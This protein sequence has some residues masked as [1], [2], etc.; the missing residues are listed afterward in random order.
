MTVA[1]MGYLKSHPETKQDAQLQKLSSP[2]ACEVQFHFVYLL[3]LFSH[4]K[5]RAPKIQVARYIRFPKV[6]PKNTYNP[7]SHGE[8]SFYASSIHI[9]SDGKYATLCYT[10]KDV[11]YFYN[12]TLTSL[13]SIVPLYH[14]TSGKYLFLKADI[15]YGLS[16]MSIPKSWYSVK[17][18]NGDIYLVY[19]IF[20]SK[21]DNSL[22]VYNITKDKIIH[23][24]RYFNTSINE[25]R[26]EDCSRILGNSFVII[27]TYRDLNLRIDLV[28]LVSETVDTFNYTIH[29]YLNNLL[30][31]VDDEIEKKSI[32][33]I[34]S[35]LNNAYIA[36]YRG[37]DWSFLGIM[38]TINN[39]EDLVPFIN[40][41][42]LYL[43][44]KSDIENI[45]LNQGTAV[46]LLK[47][48]IENNELS[49]EFTTWAGDG[50]RKLNDPTFKV[51][52][53]ANAVLFRKRY[54]LDDRYDI[55]KSYPYY[56]HEVAPNY[57]FTTDGVLEQ[58]PYHKNDYIM[59]PGFSYAYVHGMIRQ[60]G[61]HR[62]NGIN[63]LKSNVQTIVQ[64]KRS[65][66]K[67]GRKLGAII[68][69]AD[70]GEK[71][72]HPETI[73]FFNL[74]KAHKFLQKNIYTQNE[75]S[76]PFIDA[77]PFIFKVNV[78][79]KIPRILK[80]SKREL[81]S[82]S[83]RLT[84]FVY[85][86]EIGGLLYI[87]IVLFPKK[88]KNDDNDEGDTV[89]WL[90]KCNILVPTVPCEVITKL[91]LGKSGMVKDFIDAVRHNVHLIEKLGNL[92]YENM[93]V[94]NSYTL[95]Y[96]YDNILIT[97]SD[98]L[99]MKIKDIKQNRYGILQYMKQI[100]KIVSI[101]M[102]PDVYQDSY[103][104]CRIRV[105]PRFGTFPN[106]SYPL[107][108]MDLDLVKSNQM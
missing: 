66:V 51:T 85:V 70:I 16:E 74:R 20:H 107:V 67:E 106:V 72:L 28:D 59:N 35:I 41:F 60:M 45:V 82:I 79:E 95:A 92:T 54:N 90:C 80:L 23:C 65:Y 50:I 104:I 31:V 96:I 37:H 68:V 10:T 47:C 78:K 63:I 105:N 58:H 44:V 22:C 7:L 33:D 97:T 61:F 48:R 17:A 36:S 81:G 89:Y 11:C 69:E 15:E 73:T 25:K 91:H 94:G 57:I 43:G 40:Y 62:V 76:E 32:F 53:P 18:P 6:S 39:H 27:Y 49:V 55:Y 75:H 108:L 12:T 3:M 87:L 77:S 30:A 101:R 14:Y 86:D 99:D 52:I 24:V 42:E 83:N 100:P 19:I 71:F 98:R 13:Q 29:D 9:V 26:A 93:R 64:L 38:Y 5:K 102:Y 46:L 2:P 4:V 103:L 84:H 88:K 56:I 1:P 8:H 34:L 21:S